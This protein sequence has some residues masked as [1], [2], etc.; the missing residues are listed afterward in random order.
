MDGLR[1]L[2]GDLRHRLPRPLAG[3]E[4]CLSRCRFAGMRA[5]FRAVA[6]SVQAGC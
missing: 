4:A 5:T 3:P 2:Q 6:Q 1:V